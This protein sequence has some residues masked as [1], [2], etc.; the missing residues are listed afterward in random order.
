MVLIKQGISG[1][2][3]GLFFVSRKV[4]IYLFIA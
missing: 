4:A 3:D 1:R 2:F